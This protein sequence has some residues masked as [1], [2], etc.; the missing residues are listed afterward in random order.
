MNEVEKQ[1]RK[2]FKDVAND[3]NIDMLMEDHYDEME[4]E[5]GVEEDEYNMGR[6]TEDYRDGDND[7]DEDQDVGYDD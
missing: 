6:M 1:V 4:V 7:G 5:Q 2:K 3:Q